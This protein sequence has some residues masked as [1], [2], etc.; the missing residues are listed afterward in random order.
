MVVPNMIAK[1]E[2][3]WSNYALSQIH[4]C[5]SI[6]F[7]WPQVQIKNINNCK[8][9]VLVKWNSYFVFFSNMSYVLLFIIISS[10]CKSLKYFEKL[11]LTCY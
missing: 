5:R 11:L 3:E 8:F 4:A 1:N 10:L 6:A 9:E 7:N 2:D